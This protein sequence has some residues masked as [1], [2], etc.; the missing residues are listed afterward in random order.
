MS[1]FEINKIV[2]AI[3]TVALVVMVVGIIGD[4]L[5]TPSEKK[6]AVVVAT[7]PVVIAKKEKKNQEKGLRIESSLLQLKLHKL[8][9]PFLAQT[10]VEHLYY[11]QF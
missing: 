8:S 2:G 5:V 1:S 7:A 10:E 11:Y 6:D 3:L 4:A 9:L